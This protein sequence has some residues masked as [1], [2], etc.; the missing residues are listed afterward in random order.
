LLELDATD[1]PAWIYLDNQHAAI[2]DEIKKTYALALESVNVAR[3]SYEPKQPKEEELAETLRACLR[4]TAR[5][6][7]GLGKATADDDL[8]TVLQHD[9]PVWTATHHLMKQ[10]CDLVTS[11][12]P[13][14]WRIAK[15]NMNGKFK[16]VC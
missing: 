3:K 7:A 12:L 14:F 4:A 8:T 9:Q 2:L 15:A 10:L 5:E 6:D 1:E 13:G 11:S 16:R